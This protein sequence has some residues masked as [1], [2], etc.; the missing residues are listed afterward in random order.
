MITR[1]TFLRVLGSAAVGAVIAPQIPLPVEIPANE[2]TGFTEA[3]LRPL[4]YDMLRQAYEACAIG[5]RGPSLMVMH[6]SIARKLGLVY[7]VEI[8][9]AA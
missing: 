6:S 5:S 1:R 2:W 3:S 9:E 7:D 4:T 8:E